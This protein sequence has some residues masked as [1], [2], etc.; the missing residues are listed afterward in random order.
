[1]SWKG[2]LH[3]YNL[4]DIIVEK[5]KQWKMLIHFLSS[6]FGIIHY[7]KTEVTEGS[8]Y[9]VF[10]KH[11]FPISMKHTLPC[12]PQGRH[13][14]NFVNL[15]LMQIYYRLVTLPFNFIIVELFPPT[16]TDSLRNVWLSTVIV[17]YKYCHCLLPLVVPSSLLIIYTSPVYSPSIYCYFLW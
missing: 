16:C 2:E 17:Y 15:F 7:L 1:M 8:I 13:V 4:S 3:D 11:Y 9:C 5:N 12:C 6:Y 10:G 14:N